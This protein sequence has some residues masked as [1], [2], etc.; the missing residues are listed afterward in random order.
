[1]SNETIYKNIANLTESLSIEDLSTV[2]VL[3]SRPDN[4]RY[5]RS[6]QK[7]AKNSSPE[8]DFYTI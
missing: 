2:N 6:G 1:M 7:T 8:I 3:I 5:F 4:F